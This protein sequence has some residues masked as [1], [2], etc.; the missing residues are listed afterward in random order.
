MHPEIV[1]SKIKRR[2]RAKSD[3]AREEIEDLIEAAKMDMAQEGIHGQPGDPLYFQAL[4]LY[5][6]ANY[7]YDENTERFQDAYR[8]L[9]ISMALS[10]DYAEEVPEDGS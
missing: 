5:C 7:G 1:I 4:V 9:K 2:I 10:G 8:S 6:K 3:K